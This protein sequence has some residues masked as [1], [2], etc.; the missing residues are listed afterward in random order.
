VLRQL[1]RWYD[2]EVKFEGDI[3][4]RTFRGKITRDLN[5]SQVTQ[6]LQDVN[7]KFRIEGKT[8][9]VTR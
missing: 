4:A 2:I 3:P 7:I 6:L 9:I 8:L 5:L 1:A